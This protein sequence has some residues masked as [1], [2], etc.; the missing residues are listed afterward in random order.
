MMSD[1]SENAP[2]IVICGP[3]ASGKTGLV[4]RLARQFKIEVVSADSRQVYR[5]MDIGTAKPSFEEQETV[6]HHLIDIVNPDEPFSVADFV[7]KGRAAI[8]AILSRNHLPVVV[9]GTGLYIR[10]LIDGLIDAP[11]AD[12][13]LRQRLLG[14]EQEE[15]EGALYRRL[16][17]VDPEQA[18][19]IHPNNQVRIIR[20]IEVFELGGVPLSLLQ[21]RHAF[22]DSPYRLLKLY[23]N[24][25]RPLLGERID[26]RVEQ[27]I[28]DGLF[29]EVQSLLDCGYSP[30]LK[31]L[32]TI[33]YRESIRYLLREYTTDEASA[34]IKLETRQYARRQ[35]TWFKKEKSIISVDSSGETDTISTMIECFLMEKR[36]GYGQDTF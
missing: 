36:S 13:L 21:K 1:L 25:P 11:A 28:S 30:D 35:E 8:A 32:K 16:Q 23:L 4:C 10:A 34:R 12:D 17:Q 24:P 29:V 22:N 15:G 14:Y 18:Q 33:G 20:A 6:P 27:M 3:T 9:G 7:E 2:V 5:L 26:Q 31:A 19:I